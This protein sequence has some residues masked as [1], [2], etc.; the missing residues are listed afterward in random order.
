MAIC[1]LITN[2]TK[3]IE[4]KRNIESVR[5][6][7]H[8]VGINKDICQYWNNWYTSGNK[9]YYFKY[10]PYAE[11]NYINYKLINELIGE[12]LANYLNV[13]VVHY[14][15]GRFKDTY[16]L[17]SENFIKKGSKYYFLEDIDI[18]KDYTS[19]N[20]LLLLKNR[21]KNIENYNKLINEIFKLV[22]IDIYM[23]QADRND[24]NFQF[25]KEKGSIS[26]APLYDFEESFYEP[27]KDEYKSIL[28]GI[29]IYDIK[30]YLELKKLINKLLDLNIKDIL[31]KIECDKNI[32]IP[33]E[34]KEYYEDFVSDR[35]MLLKSVF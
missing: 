8:S 13:D 7:S 6:I 17:V 32:L 30:K 1:N 4:L 5:K 11:S 14:E 33:K 18:P 31:Y 23:N 10:F 20:N 12:Y 35:K 16:G 34:N 9:W 29:D 25:R 28:L 3:I 15:I 2:N 19:T 21:C 24:S 22:A 27:F 26:L